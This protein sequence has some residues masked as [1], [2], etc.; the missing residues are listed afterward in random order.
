M[1][2]DHAHTTWLFVVFCCGF[3]VGLQVGLRLGSQV[4][5]DELCQERFEHAL[6]AADSLAVVQADADCI[7][8]LE[9]R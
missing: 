3:I 5:E 2:D 7:D 4:H 9:D 1:K 8:L 6:T